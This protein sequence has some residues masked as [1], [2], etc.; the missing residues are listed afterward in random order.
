MP[1]VALYARTSTVDRQDPEMQLRDL[2]Q[3]AAA[4][5]LD[6]Y[7]EYVDQISGATTKRP[8]LDEMMADARRGKFDVAAVW[9]F[10]R[11]ARSTA[12]LVNSLAEFRRLGISF[13]SYSEA[14]DTGS[15]LGEAIFT[16]IAA[17]GQLERDVIRERIHGGLRNARARGK[18]L[19]RPKTRDDEAIRALRAKGLS[20]RAIAEKLGVSKGTV[21]NALHGG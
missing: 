11:W 2:R 19:G 20:Y 16:I 7:R 3:Y 12:M 21:Q 15:P 17:M 5:G 13:Y 1:K 8:A 9:R 14:I 6:V 18:R 4:R 10:D